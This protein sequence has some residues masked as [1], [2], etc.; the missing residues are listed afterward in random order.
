MLHELSAQLIT[1]TDQLP[2]VRCLVKPTLISLL[3]RVLQQ[4]SANAEASQNREAAPFLP[5]A[6]ALLETLQASAVIRPVPL[7]SVSARV[8]PDR[9]W[10][11]GLSTTPDA[12][13]ATEVLQAHASDGI[14]CYFSALGLHE[15]TTQTVAHHHIARLRQPTTATVAGPIGQPGNKPAPLGQW[16]FT[17][18]GLRFYLTMRDPKYLVHT[19]WRFVHELS[20]VRVT[21]LEQTLLDTLHRPLSCGGPAVV[22]EAWDTGSERLDQDK[23]AT[24]LTYVDDLRL[25]RRVGYMISSRLSALE[26]RLALM[27]TAAEQSPR[28]T[29]P[30]AL[31]GGVPY[32]TLDT[33]WHLLVP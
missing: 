33:R 15:L 24:L 19:Q 20:R 23:L 8:S 18:H 32:T 29:A 21:T 22:F 3:T 2:S 1:P 17:R 7:D 5:S 11:F 25:T 9:F 14:V 13:D 31:L 27:L 28:T 12:L 30:V 6:T 16:Q 26:P 4:V 10:T